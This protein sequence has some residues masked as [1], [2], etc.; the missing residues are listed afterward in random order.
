[1]WRIIFGWV[2]RLGVVPQAERDGALLEAVRTGDVV[3]AK[4][5]LAAAGGADKNCRSPSLLCCSTFPG[6][7]NSAALL[8]V[9]AG[10]RAMLQVLV[11]ALP[12]RA[13]HGGPDLPDGGGAPSSQ[14]AK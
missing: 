9:A 1:M 12:R 4:T 5:L 10:H 6:V 2:G 14:V 7:S 8:A 3:S 13:E 11:G